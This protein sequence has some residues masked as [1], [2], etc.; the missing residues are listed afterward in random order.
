MKCKRD[1]YQEL[2]VQKW[3]EEILGEKIFNGKLSYE[4][5]LHDGVVLCKVMNTLSP[6][7]VSKIITSGSLYFKQMENITRYTKEGSFLFVI[8]KGYEIKYV[9][10]FKRPC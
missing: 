4:D 10:G 1:L 8:S 5:T 3:I 7:S 9:L 6:G 2:E